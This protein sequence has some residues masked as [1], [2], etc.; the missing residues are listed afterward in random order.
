MDVFTAGPAT[1]LLLTSD[2]T[3][4]GV[5]TT[6]TNTGLSFSTE[7]TDIRAG[8]TNRLI[9]QFYHD[10]TLSVTMEDPL[11][12]LEYVALNLGVNLEQGGL[13]LAEEQAAVAN[14]GYVVTTKTPAVYGGKMFGWYKLTTGSNWQIG[15]IVKS[16]QEYRMTIPGAVVGATYCIKYHYQDPNARSI[17]IP[18]DFQP[19]EIH[20]I[21]I[22]QLF[23]AGAGESVSTAARVGSLLTDIPRLKLSGS[24]DLSFASGDAASV[25]LSGTALAVEDTASC[26]SDAIYGTMTE[27]L[28]G[29]DWLQDITAI[30]PT[31]AEVEL[32]TGDESTIQV[33]A[34]QGSMIA[35]KLMDN[36]DLTFTV[37]SGTGASV[38]SDG[39]ISATGTGTAYISVAV[40]KNAN[41]APAIVKVTVA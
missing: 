23:K 28:Y 17:T 40:T 30:A 14:A 27:V 33:Y 10:S 3:L 26:E 29:T 36:A 11:F 38:S 1:A 12:K 2:Y 16:G 37:D 4:F 41:V 35:P 34:I 13:A 9:G 6:F 18:A 24:M 20:V 39:K 7:N 21:L 8:L 31:D 32:S 19:S 25:P 15:N 5:A 22:N